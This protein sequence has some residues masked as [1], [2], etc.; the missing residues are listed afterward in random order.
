MNKLIEL[1]RMKNLLILI[2]ANMFHKWHNLT[3]MVISY[4]KKNIEVIMKLM[5]I[6]IK[7]IMDM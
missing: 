7:D 6:V 2:E 4:E 5:A 1:T 3:D